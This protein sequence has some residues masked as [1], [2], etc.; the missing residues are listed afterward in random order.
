MLQDLAE[1][2]SPQFP[3]RD[4][5][6]LVQAYRFFYADWPYF[7]DPERNRYMLGKVSILMCILKVRI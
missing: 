1:I 2:F 5:E 6:D 3:D 7:E 4:T